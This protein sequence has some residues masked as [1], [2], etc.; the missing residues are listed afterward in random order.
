MWHFFFLI[1]ISI[2]ALK[3]LENFLRKKKTKTVE[4]FFPCSGRLTYVFIKINTHGYFPEKILQ[5]II[6]QLSNRTPVNNCFQRRIQNPVKTQKWSFLQTKVNNWKPL[7]I[8]AKNS[9]LDIWLGSEYVSGFIT[10]C[11]K[12]L[13]ILQ[14]YLITDRKTKTS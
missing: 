13:F 14:V 10:F 1:F 4:Y 7:T 12:N 9:I 2:A 6:K 5:T 8:F 11:R 3:N